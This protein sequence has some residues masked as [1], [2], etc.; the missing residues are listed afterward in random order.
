MLN[1][2]G[3]DLFV[4]A[5]PSHLH[6]SATITALKLGYHVLSEKPMAFNLFDFDDLVATAEK[7]GRILSPF[8]NNRYQPFFAQIQDVINSGNLGEILDVRSVWGS[9][10]RRWDWQTFQCNG[11]GCLFNSG[12]HAIDQAL[13]FFPSS[14]IPKVE[15][16]LL[17]NNELGGDADDY[18]N[19][20][21]TAP[22]CPRV[23][24][25]ISQYIAYNPGDIYT[26]SGTRGGLTGN[27]KNLNWKYYEWQKAPTQPLWK[28]WSIDR[29]YPSEDLQWIEEK[30]EL[31]V[32]NAGKSSGYTLRSFLIGAKYIYEN[33]Y[34]TIVNEGQL[35]ITLSEVRKQIAMME[36]CKLQNPLPKKLEKWIYNI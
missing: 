33:L 16:T 19:I 31:D 17:C 18:C 14:V 28:P 10:S 35:A 9:F 24:I 7:A 12:P 3:F 32:K 34:N 25:L 27:Y 36:E 15:S 30:W 11:G 22:N 20:V 26:I 13:Q 4:N 2:G 5:I 29:R 6:L 1:A 23:E 21:L 8:Q